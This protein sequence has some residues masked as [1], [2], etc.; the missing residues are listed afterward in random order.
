VI[1]HSGLA[2]LS[3]DAVILL[4][5]L[6]FA[7]ICVELNRP[8]S[9]L[10]GAL[11]LL[12]FLLA[13]ASLLRFDLSP[14]GVTLT[15]SAIFLLLVGLRRT[16]HPLVAVAATL[17]LTLGLGQLVRGP[18]RTHALT[19]I[20]CGMLTGAGTS[21]LTRIARRARLNKGLD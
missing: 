2:S 7:L 4:L 5:T 15:L 10:P 11:G 13:L 3:P 20:F 19:T 9:I 21:I 17:A 8:G 12:T 6:G 1:A 18:T 14:V 16:L